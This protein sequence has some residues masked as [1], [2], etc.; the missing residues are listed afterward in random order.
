MSDAERIAG[1][2]NLEP[3]PIGRHAAIDGPRRYILL[4]RAKVFSL[5]LECIRG[6][7]AIRYKFEGLR[8]GAD[9]LVALALH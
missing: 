7:S 1:C 8:A 6:P 3:T 4:S 9:H 5:F 2:L